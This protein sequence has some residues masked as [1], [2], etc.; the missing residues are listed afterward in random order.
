MSIDGLAVPVQVCTAVRSG[1]PDAVGLQEG[2]AAEVVHPGMLN[3]LRLSPGLGD[4]IRRHAAGHPPVGDPPARVHLL[5][6]EAPEGTELHIVPFQYFFRR[7][8]LNLYPPCD[9]RS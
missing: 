4:L 7:L 3:R 9:R 2:R 6:D 1:D 8:G 5:R